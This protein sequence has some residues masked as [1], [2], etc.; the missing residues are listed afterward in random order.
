MSWKYYGFSV[1][2]GCALAVLLCGGCGEDSSKKTGAPAAAPVAQS[3]P[4]PVPQTAAIEVTK[5]PVMR[6]QLTTSAPRPAARYL[7]EPEINESLAKTS[8]VVPVTRPQTPPPAPAPKVSLARMQLEAAR[9]FP[10]LQTDDFASLSASYDAGLEPVKAPAAR[11]GAAP[12]SR[13]PQVL[14]SAGRNRGM[15]MDGPELGEL[16]HSA[17]R[18]LDDD[19]GPSVLDIPPEPRN[20]APSARPSR[21]AVPAKP[22][23]APKFEPAPEIG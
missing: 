14:A 12:A 19:I 8:T 15:D 23:L 2:P 21:P 17:Y 5:E 1:L 9:D 3:A 4:A 20:F 7:S 11:P 18:G 13:K 6:P 16:E 10:E 22:R